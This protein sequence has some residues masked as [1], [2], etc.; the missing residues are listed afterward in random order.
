MVTDLDHQTTNYE[1]HFMLL[2]WESGCYLFWELA[3]LFIAILPFLPWFVH[4]VMWL[5]VLITWTKNHMIFKRVNIAPL[6]M[7]WSFVFKVFSLLISKLLFMGSCAI[8]SWD[9]Q[10]SKLLILS[11]Q[12]IKIF[13]LIILQKVYWHTGFVFSPRT[14]LIIKAMINLTYWLSDESFDY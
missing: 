1:W 5:V 3:L 9:S 11:F 7:L 8:A 10:F 13:L 6:W 4:F 2:R 14:L 12:W